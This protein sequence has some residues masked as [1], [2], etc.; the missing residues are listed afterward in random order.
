M[1]FHEFSC[2]N[3]QIVMKI[4]VVQMLLFVS[5]FVFFVIS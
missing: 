3:T 5:D 2:Y 1:Y 4:C